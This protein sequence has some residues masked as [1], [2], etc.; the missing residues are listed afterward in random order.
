MFQFSLNIGVYLNVTPCSFLHGSA[1][2]QVAEDDV[3]PTG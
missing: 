2:Q 3:Q 1:Y